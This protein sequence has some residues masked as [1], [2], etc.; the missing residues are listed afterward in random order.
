MEKQKRKIALCG[1]LNQIA[2][3]RGHNKPKHGL[4]VI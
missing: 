4:R 2:K 1:K 3:F